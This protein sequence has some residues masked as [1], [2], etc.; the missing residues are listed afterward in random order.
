LPD[1]NGISLYDIDEVTFTRNKL[2][3][4]GYPFSRA[5]TFIIKT[6]HAKNKKAEVRF[7]SQYD[8]EWTKNAGALV[9]AVLFPG[10]GI[11]DNTANKP[12]HFIS[13]QVSVASAIGKL[14]LYASGQLDGTRS[15]GLFEHRSVDYPGLYRDTTD[16]NVHTKQLN[17]K[18]LVNIDYSFTDKLNA[19]ITGSYFNGATRDKSFA[20]GSRP[21]AYSFFDTA[22]SRT[23]LQY[24][25]IG[26]FVSWQ[27]IKNMSNRFSFEYSDDHFDY[28]QTSESD[29]Y[30]NGIVY[31]RISAI[32][33]AKPYIKNYLFRDQLDY[34]ILSGRKFRAGATA[35]F[36]YMH[37][38]LYYG[39]TTTALQNGSAYGYSINTRSGKEKITTLNPSIHFSYDNIFNAYGGYAFI[40]NKGISGYSKN[41]RANPY[42]EITV[43]LKNALRIAFADRLDIS[44]DYAD[45]TE[46]SAT[47]YWLPSITPEELTTSGQFFSSTQVVFI[48]NPSLQHIL[49]KNKL[50][51]FQINSAFINNRLLVG[52]ELTS[53]Q[54]QRIFI[55]AV[56]LGG[57]TNGYVAVA[58]NESQKGTS[59]HVG[60]K[61]IDRP[62]RYLETRLN[63][64]FPNI[65]Y[66]INGVEPLDPKPVSYTMQAGWQNKFTFREFSIQANVLYGFDRKYYTVDFNQALVQK[67][68]NELVLNYLLIGYD[69]SHTHNRVTRNLEIF[70]HARNLLS[71]INAKDYYRYLRYGGGGINFRFD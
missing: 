63:L 5:G 25:H 24:Y 12:G 68:I 54:S 22:S 4:E 57:N 66:D 48:P 13:N 7:N 60:F 40:L 43:N 59:V 15:P 3:G 58:G 56:P 52:A 8:I 55:V 29:T 50:T 38:K 28:K 9:D 71:S 67:K 39:S 62:G 23:P 21:P 51:G 53:L 27:P 45:L 42:A 10:F 18:S 30:A 64:L 14:Q 46:N 70:V 20:S 35:I 2:N 41:S 33:V 1:V 34:D 31:S 37:E 36:S 6:K 47:N 11:E 65:K 26:S 44:V 19:G 69:L 49:F 32:T 16:A 61:L 17:F